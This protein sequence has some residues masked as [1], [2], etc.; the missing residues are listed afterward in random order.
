MISPFIMDKSLPF[1]ICE[2]TINEISMFDYFMC[3]KDVDIES[4]MCPIYNRYEFYLNTE[5]FNDC[6]KMYGIWINFGLLQDK[7]KYYDLIE[8][9]LI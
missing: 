3:E 8:N 7:Y 2:I 1:V 6:S 4:Q 5:Y 9:K